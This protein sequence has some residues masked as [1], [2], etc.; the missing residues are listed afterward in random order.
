MLLLEIRLVSNLRDAFKDHNLSKTKKRG[1]S[2]KKMGCSCVGALE[3]T[4]MQGIFYRFFPCCTSE[5]GFLL[6]YK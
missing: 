4:D 3:C 2:Y 6:N 5:C 1:C